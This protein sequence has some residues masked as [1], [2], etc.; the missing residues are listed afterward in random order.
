MEI[1]II[2]W[3]THVKPWGSAATK[4]HVYIKPTPGKVWYGCFKDDVLM[5]FTFYTV[6]KGICRIGGA[7]VHPDHRGQ[8]AY[9]VMMRHCMD[10]AELDLCSMIDI[11]PVHP[12]YF[13][14]FGFKLIGKNAHGVPHMVKAL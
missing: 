14:P 5:G 9:D 1:R 6:K 8:G 10:K 3:E 2:D 7:Y 11:F 12:H 4:E 13:E